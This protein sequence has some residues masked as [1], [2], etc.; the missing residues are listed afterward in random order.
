[1][2][3]ILVQAVVQV[4]EH[5]EHHGT[6][7]RSFE[8][9]CNEFMKKR[10]HEQIKKKNKHHVNC[11]SRNVLFYWMSVK[12]NWKVRI[13]L[14]LIPKCALNMPRDKVRPVYVARYCADLCSF[15]PEIF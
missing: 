11:I 4:W 9:E 6:M 15:E 10:L 1:M 8:E 12:G 7:Q 14:N 13:S 5:T 3:I 2:D